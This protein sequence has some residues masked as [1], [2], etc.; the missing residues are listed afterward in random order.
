MKLTSLL[1]MLAAAALLL[2]SCDDYET[3][4]E[5]KEKERNAINQYIKDNGINVI[6]EAE[7]KTDTT[8]DVSRNEYVLFSSS[9]IYMQI[10]RRGCGEMLKNGETATVL[11]RFTEYNILGDS[12]Q[13]TN[14]YSYYSDI[15]ETMTITMGK[16]VVSSGVFVSGSSLMYSQYGTTAVPNGWL[17]PFS[18]IRVGRQDNPNDEIAKVNLIVPAAQGQSSASSQVYPCHYEITFEKGR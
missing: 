14:N 11:S 9:G 13:L 10:V 4:A 16:G 1:P 12:V 5:K 18:Y 2:Q 17:V 6:S 8:T 15:P 3:Y 7:F